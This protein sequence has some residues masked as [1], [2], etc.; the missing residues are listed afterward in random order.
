MTGERR[1]GALSEEILGLL[2]ETYDEYG[3][4]IWLRQWAA[5]TVDERNVLEQH[6][7]LGAAGPSA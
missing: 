2:D 3:R 1:V 6:L 5:S 7:R 4:N